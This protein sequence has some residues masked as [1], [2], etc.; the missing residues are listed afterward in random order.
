MG[1]VNRESKKEGEMKERRGREGGEVF[2]IL[3]TLIK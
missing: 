3:S 1:E 2:H